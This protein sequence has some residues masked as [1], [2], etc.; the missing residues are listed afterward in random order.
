MGEPTGYIGVIITMVLA[1]YAFTK[2]QHSSYF[3][4]G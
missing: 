3:E 1:F 4:V 2:F